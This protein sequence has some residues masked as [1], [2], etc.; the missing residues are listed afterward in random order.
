MES[1]I[2]IELVRRVLKKKYVI[3]ELKEET[4]IYWNAVRKKISITKSYL[5]EE[6]SRKN[7]NEKGKN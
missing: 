2:N 4:V 3:L 1:I 5:A 7:I 6:N